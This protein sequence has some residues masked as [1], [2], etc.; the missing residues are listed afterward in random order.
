[1]LY[2]YYSTR[3]TSLIAE[4]KAT[5]I[6]T[7]MLEDLQRMQITVAFFKELRLFLKQM[8]L[9]WKAY[10]L[11]VRCFLKIQVKMEKQQQ[12]QTNQEQ[13]NNNNNNNKT[14]CIPTVVS[15]SGKGTQ[16]GVLGLVWIRSRDMGV[17]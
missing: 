14:D 5:H 4:E 11:S 1:M 9:Y 6:E 3:T 2:R 13:T 7:R 8:K 10:N 17:K 16:R 12:Q 15:T